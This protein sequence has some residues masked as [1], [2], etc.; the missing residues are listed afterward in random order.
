M[1]RLDKVSKI[2]PQGE[3]L[4]EVTWELKTGDRIGL[5]GANGAG[6]TTQFRIIMGEVEPTT[7]D[8]I[9][10]SG[11]KLAYLTQEFEMDQELTIRDEMSR[12]FAECHAVKEAL[13]AVHLKMETATPE[14]LEKLL[15]KMD[16]LQHEYEHKGGYK[17]DMKVDKLLPELGFTLADGD[18]QVKE[19][20]GGWQM[21]IGLGKVMLRDP[22]VILL[23]E[24]TNHLDL[25]TVEWLEGY[26]KGITKPI[27]IISHDRQFLDRLCTKI[28]EV[29]RGVSTVYLGNYSSYIEQRQQIRDAQQAAYERQQKEMEVQQRF[30]D[31]FRASATRSTQAKSREKQLEKIELIEEPDSELRTLKF[32]FPPCVTS[33]REVVR[34]KN[35]S[36][37][38]GDNILFL[39]VNLF[40]ERG[41]KIAF[42]GPNGCGKSTLLRLIMGLEPPLEGQ[43]SFGPHNI[44]PSYFYQNQAEALDLNKTVLDTIADEVP[45][46]KTEEIRGLLGKFLFS[47]DAVFKKVE[48]LSGG[49]KARLALAKML[50]G[51]ANVLL[52][53]EPTNHLDIP[54]KETIEEALQ[55][56]EGSIL[57][58]SHDRY[59]I[60]KVANK[61][62]EVRDGELKFYNG[63]YEYYLERKELERLKESKA[64]EQAEHEAKLAAKKAKDKAKQQE[65]AKRQ[66]EA[67]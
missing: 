29:E 15:Y 32:Q 48:S 5:V 57:L 20:S 24:P 33:G 43:V 63:N 6:K 64:K 38:Y 53:D 16:N 40:V 67:R 65:K 52:L 17:I 19:F 31:R 23:D 28:V 49:E 46:W 18:R 8:V 4:K 60:S 26:L 27:A 7:G 42:L 36:H 9:R 58:V 37:A 30:V 1:I 12:A 22:D 50:T 11:T 41:D 47:G 10:N 45:K 56:F 44:H 2:Y 55:K 51:S 25:E 39:G 62:V 14:E 13:H 21:R 54:A 66:D 3:I 61:I 34:I 35:L 59:M